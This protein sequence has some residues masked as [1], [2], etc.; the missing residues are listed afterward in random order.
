MYGN[1]VMRILNKV[2]GPG[3][4]LRSAAEALEHL[5]QLIGNRDGAAIVVIGLAMPILIG[6]MG[7]ATEVSYWHLHQRTMQNAAD[8]AA[9][10]AGTAANSDYV[11]EAKA[12]TSQYGFT[13]GQ[14]NISVSVSNPATASGC[15]RKC[16]VVTI[17]DA[18]PLLLSQIV[19]FHGNTTV[20]GRPM[21]NI[22]TSAVATSSGAYTYCVLALAGSGKQGL[23]ANG[24]SKADLNGCNTMSNTTANCNGHDLN[25]SVGNAHGNNSGC[26]NVQNS[27][28]PVAA[29][30]YSGLAAYIPVNTCTS[31][32]QEPAKTNDPPLPVSNQWSGTV[33][34]SGNTIVCGD[35]QLTGNTTINA[36]SGAVLVIENGQLDT[37]GY[38]LRT[39]SGSA[40][41]IVFTGS[42]NPSYEHIP[43]GNGTLDIAAPTSGV[44][45]GVAIY[46]DPTLTKNID[47]AAAGNSPT[48]N[49]SGLVYL[50]HSSVT[51]SGA[52]NK[53]GYGASC[54]VLVVDNLTINGTGSIF[55]HDTQ[56]V[57]GGLT[58]PQGGS[59]GMLV[60]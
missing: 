52:V 10:A 30:P 55:A 41:T 8:A 33:T 14:G 5:R 16:Y 23:S 2:I 54:F 39:A 25:A 37:N 45:S 15:T 49:I 51:L 56:C 57:S 50:P 18:V 47:I 26:G 12:V 36:E 31:Y 34:L 48:W 40:L 58:A 24:A 9:I 27:N 22:T 42:S 53:S 19:G 44:W 29:D 7:L 6:V 3:T 60:N 4:R 1:A 13:D 35:Q 46:Q 43:T 32:P 20:D 59:R 17:S 11:S 21:N 38:T 28:V